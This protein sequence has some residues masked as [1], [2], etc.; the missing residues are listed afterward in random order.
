MLPILFHKQMD[1]SKQMEVFERM[2][3]SSR[4]QAVLQYYSGFTKLTNPLIRDFISTYSQRQ[5][6]IEDLLP[7]L[8]CFYEA[9]KASLCKLVASRFT[10]HIELPSLSPVDYLAIGYFITSLLSLPS[11]NIQLRIKE[12]DHTRSNF[13]LLLLELLKYPI[14]SGADE[15]TFKRKLELE[16][17]S[18]N[19][20]GTE[21]ELIPPLLEK[22][23]VL[24]KLSLKILKAI[25]FSNAKGNICGFAICDIF[26]SLQH[27]TSLVHFNLSNTRLVAT[28]DTAQALTTMLQVNKTLTHLDLSTNHNFSDRGASCVY[29]GLQHNTTL[30]YLNLSNTEMTDKGA[31]YIAQT[32]ESNCSLQSLDISRNK[33][34]VRGLA[35]IAKVT[36]LSAKKRHIDQSYQLRS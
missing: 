6:T 7:L 32:L 4:F 13:K 2:F 11:S 16:F 34:S 19:F 23:A 35:C 22:S 25:P 15:A 9:Q 33:L 27:N 10:Q 28:E 29:Q 1:S 36:T 20:N 21:T 24:S 14:K 17:C 5:S 8:H 12:V 30:V 3:G 31:E 18:S 26:K